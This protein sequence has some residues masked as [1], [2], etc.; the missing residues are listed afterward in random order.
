MFPGLAVEMS[1]HYPRPASPG[2]RKA[3][4]E[5]HAAPIAARDASTQSYHYW[6][7]GQ[8]SPGVSRGPRKVSRDENYVTSVLPAPLPTPAVEVP[9]PTSPLQ[10]GPLSSKGTGWF[11]TPLST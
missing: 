7:G 3:K 8:K 4:L 10:K 5:R 11:P 9:H 2:A 6:K 1:R